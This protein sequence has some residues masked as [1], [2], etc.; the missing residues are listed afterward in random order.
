MAI[1]VNVFQSTLPQGEWQFTSGKHIYTKVISIHTPTRGVTASDIT[2]SIWQR[3][4]N[5]HSHKGSDGT[6]IS[7]DFSPT[8]FQSTLPQGEWLRT[9][10]TVLVDC[11]FNPHSHKGSDF[12][13]DSMLI[14]CRY[15]N[16][17]SHKGSDWNVFIHLCRYYNFNP[18]SHK[19]SD[20]Q[21]LY[22][23]GGRRGFQSTLPQGEWQLFSCGV[24]R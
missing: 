24:F 22:R 10:A 13:R 9:S 21:P 18:H 17:H 11:Y 3:N 20:I 23:T 1:E 15:F 19:G 8:W 16:P 7:V 5:P 2:W 12:N 14:V 4:F 6:E